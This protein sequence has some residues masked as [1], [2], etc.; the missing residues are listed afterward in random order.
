[1]DSLES[2][3][4]K[5]IA[6]RWNLEAQVGAVY[7]EAPARYLRFDRSDT[8]GDSEDA[9]LSIE[10]AT[11]SEWDNSVLEDRTDLASEPTI[12]S[13]AARG[14]PRHIRRVTKRKLL[15]GCMNADQVW[16]KCL[17][18][19]SSLPELLAQREEMHQRM[20]EITSRTEAKSRWHRAF[21]MAMEGHEVDRA[22]RNVR[23]ISNRIRQYMFF[24]ESQNSVLKLSSM[25]NQ[26]DKIYERK[27]YGRL[28]GLRDLSRLAYPID[29]LIDARTF[30]CHEIVQQELSTAVQNEVSRRAEPMELQRWDRETDST[31]QQSEVGRKSVNKKL[32]DLQRSIHRTAHNASTFIKNV[33]KTLQ[34]VTSDIREF[35][36]THANLKKADKD[37]HADL[38]EQQRRNDGY[39]DALEKL[40]ARRKLAEGRLQSDLETL[41]S[42]HA[43]LKRSL[44]TQEKVH[45]ESKTRASEMASWLQVLS[46]QRLEKSADLMLEVHQERMHRRRALFERIYWLE[47]QHLKV[48][49][50]KLRD[51]LRSS[52]ET[53][54]QRKLEKDVDQYR[55][56]A[57]DTKV[58]LLELR[59]RCQ[60]LNV[61]G[62]L[63]DFGKG[64][65]GA[66]SAERFFDVLSKELNAQADW[67]RGRYMDVR[68]STGTFTLARCIRRSTPMSLLGV[69]DRLLHQRQLKMMVVREM[70]RA[71]MG[72][73]EKV[74]Q[75]TQRFKLALLSRRH[76]HKEDD[77][78]SLGE[79]SS[80]EWEDEI[81]RISEGIDNETLR[82]IFGEHAEVKDGIEHTE[83]TTA[84]VSKKTTSV[85]VEAGHADSR[86][87][88]VTVA[89]ASLQLRQPSFLEES[90]TPRTGAFASEASWTRA[91]TGT[92]HKDDA[93]PGDDGLDELKDGTEGVS[94]GID[95]ETLWRIVAE[96]AEAMEDIEC[97][98]T[99]ATSAEISENPESSEAEGGHAYGRQGS[100]AA[101]LA[102]LQQL[103]S[104][105]EPHLRRELLQ[106][107]S[108]AEAAHAYGR[109][110]SVA[111]ALVQLQRLSSMEPDIFLE[112]STTPRA[113]ACASKASWSLQLT[114]EWGEKMPKIQTEQEM[115]AVY[116]ARVAMRSLWII[117]GQKLVQA[118]KAAQIY[119]KQLLGRHEVPRVA[120]EEKLE[121]LPDKPGGAA[122]TGK[123]AS[124]KRGSVRRSVVATKGK[125]GSKIST[126]PTPSTNPKSRSSLR[127]SLKTG[128]RASLKHPMTPARSEE[129]SIFV[130]QAQSKATQIPKGQK[131]NRD[132]NGLSAR[133]ASRA[134]IESK[135]DADAVALMESVISIGRAHAGMAPV[136]S[137]QPASPQ[138]SAHGSSSS[139]SVTESAAE[140]ANEANERAMAHVQRR[141]NVVTDLLETKA[142][143]NQVQAS[144][145]E[146]ELEKSNQWAEDWIRRKS[147]QEGGDQELNE[148]DG[149][150][151]L[152]RTGLAAIT[153]VEADMALGLDGPAELTDDSSDEE[154]LQRNSETVEQFIQSSAA[155]TVKQK[156]A[157][158]RI[159]GR[160]A[161]RLS[162]TMKAPLILFSKDS[163]RAKG[164]ESRIQGPSP[165]SK[166]TSRKK[167]GPSKSFSR[168]G[169]ED[170]V[171]PGFLADPLVMQ[172]QRKIG[173][174]RSMRGHS[175]KSSRREVST[176]TTREPGDP[177]GL[178]EDSF[179]ALSSVQSTEKYSYLSHRAISEA[180][181][182]DPRA[183]RS[184]K[185]AVLPRLVAVRM[186]G[187][188]DAEASMYANK[189]R[190]G[191]LSAAMTQAAR[192]QPGKASRSS[193]PNSKQEVRVQLEAKQ[194]DAPDDFMSLD[195]YLGLSPDGPVRLFQEAALEEEALGLSVPKT[196]AQPA[197][198]SAGDASEPPSPSSGWSHGRQ[199]EVAARSS[200]TAGSVLTTRP[201]ECKPMLSARALKFFNGHLAG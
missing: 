185:G 36:K 77:A 31:L 201:K 130:G 46:G 69:A 28:T 131:L 103:S 109:Q 124:K 119:C 41:R 83:T 19:A 190:K 162:T 18:P 101:A 150:H 97:I 157:G 23:D 149:R 42:E 197:G 68:F 72:M 112:E 63:K 114:K 21:E 152:R 98:A 43:I 86:E 198:R 34:I 93:S 139:S 4:C 45:E 57:G 165:T 153:P 194:I 108:R 159:P 188:G 118:Q 179:M 29:Q 38:F 24:G 183:R 133:R 195:D 156:Q 106:K 49:M 120:F 127:G 7:H 102:Q 96:H 10:E 196:R 73:E 177:E 138:S 161:V 184:E 94:E 91:F 121:H 99:G 104:S 147:M 71:S 178:Q 64:V 175:Q 193:R 113:G 169:Q 143:R 135:P 40:T 199:S 1:M 166:S 174:H 171:S 142:L 55:A 80:D 66:S 191:A 89:A 146:E 168:D 110:G 65:D 82:Q 12:R 53:L 90:P 189:G 15:A 122:T 17:V 186:D 134:S 144:L 54:N 145:G 74:E 52:T 200:R 26:Y 79:D 25:L 115:V 92:G 3:G 170:A 20:K 33:K 56:I 9:L 5:E 51:R 60:E 154:L 158:P 95:M 88:S 76:S 123:A 13:E 132:V 6:H 137:V 27:R 111:A 2:E 176:S 11:Y 35:S 148:L 116:I 141:L 14:H 22:L 129:Q 160:E 62:T 78:A 87:G 163:S 61:D 136:I 180:V 172:L 16:T 32:D 70:R 50:A 117:Q 48:K 182:D 30:E 47:L 59:G 85:E 105:E 84:A 167:Q 151:L 181:R 107:I 125:R 140:S 44:E 100:V 37:Y 67:L 155:A 8:E 39:Q 164:R 128:L 81:E 58:L 75:L 192:M 187:P 173:P 126:S